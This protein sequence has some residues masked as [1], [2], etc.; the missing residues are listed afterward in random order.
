MRRAFYV[1]RQA[2]ATALDQ[3]VLQQPRL[4][5][6]KPSDPRVSVQPIREADFISRLHAKLA[7]GIAFEPQLQCVL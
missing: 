2:G 5:V 1:E 4:I 7:C 6:A 3:L